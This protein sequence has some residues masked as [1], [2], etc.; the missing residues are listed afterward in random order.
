MSRARELSLA[1][2]GCTVHRGADE[3]QR[4]SRP[5]DHLTANIQN[6]MDAGNAALKVS[7]LLVDRCGEQ[8]V[9]DSV[10]PW[11]TWLR[12]ESKT[13]KISRGGLCV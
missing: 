9:A 6:A 10:S 5:W 3:F 8:E 12:W 7:P 11:S 2:N 4:D 1:P 13:Q